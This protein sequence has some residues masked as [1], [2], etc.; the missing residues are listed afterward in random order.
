MFLLALCTVRK[1]P[2]QT[3]ASL[4]ISVLMFAGSHNQHPPLI[5][6]GREN[7]GRR[8]RIQST[9]SKTDTFEL[10]WGPALSVRLIG[11][12]IKGVGVRFTEV[13]VKREST[14]IGFFRFHITGLQKRGATISWA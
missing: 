1:H 14:V 6:D 8:E 3:V 12:Q 4:L 9:L 13:S 5:H 10:P 7:V 2:T 11:G